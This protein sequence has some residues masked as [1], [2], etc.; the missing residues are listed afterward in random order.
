MTQSHVPVLYCPYCSW[1]DLRPRPEPHDVWE[2]LNCRQVFVVRF[3][4]LLARE[5]AR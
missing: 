5:A 4:G 3:V 2:C 1:D